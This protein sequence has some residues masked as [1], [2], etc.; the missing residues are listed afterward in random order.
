MMHT[1]GANWD[2]NF[3]GYSAIDQILFQMYFKHRMR[4]YQ[5]FFH[6]NPDYA[7]WYGWSMMVQ[8]LGEIKHMAKAMRADHQK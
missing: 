1:N 4:A 7:Y 3:D 2:E 8:D 6:V 5:A